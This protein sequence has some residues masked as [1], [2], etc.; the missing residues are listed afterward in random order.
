MRAEEKDKRQ[1]IFALA[2]SYI[3]QLKAKWSTLISEEDFHQ[4]PVDKTAEKQGK[5]K[6]PLK[7]DKGGVVKEKKKLVAG[8]SDGAL[9]L[10][11]SPVGSIGSNHTNTPPPRI[12]NGTISATNSPNMPLMN[13]KKESAPTS[14]LVTSA[15][16]KKDAPVK[17]D[18]NTQKKETSSQKKDTVSVKKEP[19]SPAHTSKKE[20][21]NPP[22][23]GSQS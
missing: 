17:K 3:G 6:Q 15:L 11:S 16:P 21:S 18:T 7:E 19:Q 2:T 10:C 8:R 4:K 20:S 12:S 14:P 13:L 5:T 22:S 23:S 9:S 1:D